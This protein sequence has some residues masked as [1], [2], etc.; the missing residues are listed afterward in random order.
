VDPY[1][2]HTDGHRDDR[3]ED[4]EQEEQ[5]D[6]LGGLDLEQLQEVIVES[7]QKTVGCLGETYL[8]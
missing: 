1:E 7:F 3:A 8:H 5:E 6:A 2:A 4:A